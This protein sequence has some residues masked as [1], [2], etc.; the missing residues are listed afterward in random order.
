MTPV[1]GQDSGDGLKRPSS[2]SPGSDKAEEA[3]AGKGGQGLARA[4]VHPTAPNCDF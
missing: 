3:S 4:V 1:V 2:L